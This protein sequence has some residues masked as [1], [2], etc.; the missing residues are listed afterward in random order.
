MAGSISEEDV[1]KV[2]TAT[3]IV[4]LFSEVVPLQQKGNGY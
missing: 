4:Q 2:R 3:D 1:E